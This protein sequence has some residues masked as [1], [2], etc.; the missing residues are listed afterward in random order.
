[1]FMEPCLLLLV[2]IP[3]LVVLQQARSERLEGR[4]G[5]VLTQKPSTRA[6]SA[7]ATILSGRRSRAQ[8]KKE[9]GSGPKMPGAGLQALR[10]SSLDSRWFGAS[11]PDAEV[12]SAEKEADRRLPALAQPTSCESVG[13]LVVLCASSLT[14]EKKGNCKHI[15]LQCPIGHPDLHW[16]EADGLDGLGKGGKGPAQQSKWR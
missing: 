6:G 8:T 9:S 13:P 10:R 5:Y 14:S 16:G 3:G 11:S 1:M 15:A 4:T 12:F 2:F 7:F